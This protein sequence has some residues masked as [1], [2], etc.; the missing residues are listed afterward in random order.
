MSRVLA[1]LLACLFVVGPGADA[2]CKASCLPAPAPAPT[3]HDVMTTPS[4]DGIV[5][6]TS[7]C[8][9]D[10][11]L[12]VPPGDTRRTSLAPAPAALTAIVSPAIEPAVVGGAATVRVTRARPTQACPRCIVLRI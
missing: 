6:S 1:V 9:R 2:L 11:V 12:A 7:T 4:L 10:I 8:R 5:A 3:C